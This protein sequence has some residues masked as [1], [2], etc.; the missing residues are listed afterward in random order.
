[1]YQVNISNNGDYSF[2]VNSQGGEFVVD[3]K[4]QAGANPPDVLL[5][6][7][8]TCL[9]VYL[10]KYAEGAKLDLSSFN[11]SAQAEFSKDPPVCFREITVIIDLKGAKLD[12]R[13]INAMLEFIKNCPV[14]NTLKNNPEVKV[15]INR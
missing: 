6:S 5:A 7:L 15:M 3:M 10:R 14:H 8:A 13:R 4:G 1:M 9:G 12:E 11:I 2:R